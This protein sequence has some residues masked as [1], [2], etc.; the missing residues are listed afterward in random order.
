[1][2]LDETPSH[3][4]WE[5]WYRAQL[6]WQNPKSCGTGEDQALR[7]KHA[8]REAT[9]SPGLI[10]AMHPALWRNCLTPTGAINILLTLR[11]MKRVPRPVVGFS[12]PKPARAAVNLWPQFKTCA[13]QLRVVRG[14]LRCWWGSTLLG[15][16]SARSP[17]VGT[18]GG[19]PNN[20][21]WCRL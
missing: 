2:F 9:P 16:V 20:M 21:A 11:M 3:S 13:G 17:T 18:R 5:M 14:T 8:L 15:I 19:L 7:K 1:M 10:L 12:S 6:V 4:A